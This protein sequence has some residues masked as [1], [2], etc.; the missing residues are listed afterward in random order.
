MAYTGMRPGQIMRL[1]PDDWDDTAAHD[2]RARHGEGPRHEGVRDAA[3]GSQARAAL[4]AFDTLDA[5]GTF[6]WAP[7]ARMWKS[8]IAATQK[9]KRRR[10]CRTSAGALRSSA[11]LRDGDLPRD[12]RHPGRTEA[13]RPFLAPR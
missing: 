9:K 1:T 3:L 12:W 7:M 10:A 4:K 8:G 6:T 5:W 13:A 2:H 11:L